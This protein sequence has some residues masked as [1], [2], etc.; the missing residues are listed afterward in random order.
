[1]GRGRPLL[2]PNT[3]TRRQGCAQATR[4]HYRGTHML[5]HV[6]YGLV[7][8]IHYRESS[9]PLTLVTT[10]SQTPHPFT[11]KEGLTLC[12]RAWWV[13]CVCSH[14][15]SGTPTSEAEKTEKVKQKRHLPI[16]TPHP[17]AGTVS[18]ETPG[19]LLR[20]TARKQLW[21]SGRALTVLRCKGQD[22][23]SIYGCSTVWCPPPTL[24]LKPG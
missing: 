3:Y 10:C 14:V 7:I 1:M 21:F 18:L 12:P 17:L 8:R 13:M 20:P 15:H 24:T 6:S 19:I 5:T 23:H 16:H 22:R 2:P 11:P 4:H 9:L